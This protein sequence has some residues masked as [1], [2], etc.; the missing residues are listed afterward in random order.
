[1]TGKNHALLSLEL[2]K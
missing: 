1:M 2:S